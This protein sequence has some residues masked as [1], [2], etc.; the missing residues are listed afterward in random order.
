MSDGGI[1]T[2]DPMDR[3]SWNGLAVIVA[4]GGSACAEPEFPP[5]LPGGAGVVSH[6]SEEF[7]KRPDTLRDEVTVATHAPTIDF[8]FYPGQ[9]YPGKPWSVWGDGVAADG[10]YFSAI[11]DHLA[12]QGTA[13][14]YEFDPV[15]KALR[16][17]VDVKRLLALPAGHYVPGKI[18]S[19]VDLGKDGW[20]YYATHRGSTRVTTEEFHYEGDWILRTHPGTGQSEV[21][22]RGPVPKHCIPC[23]VLDPERLIFYGGTAPGSDG[24]GGIQFFAYDIGRRELLHA[25]EGGPARAMIFAKSTGRVYFTPGKEESPLMRYDPQSGGGPVAIDGQIGIRAATEETSDGIV[26]TVSSGQGAE[27]VLYAFNTRTEEIENL[28]PAAVGTQQYIT[29]IDVDPSG[30]FLYYVP[31]A[32][33][34]SEKDGC[35]VVQFDLRTRKKKVVAFPHPFFAEKY[36]STLQGTF[37]SAIDPAGDKLYITWNNS[38]DGK[39][40]DTCALT[41][42]HIPESERE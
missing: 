25:G 6:T 3:I 35:A 17:L 4:M 27:A 9:A 26:Y 41:V 32:H 38:R 39:T 42:V 15:A 14:V 34:G 11:G 36:G 33:G 16:E 19:R 40:W 7:L 5:R 13:R 31:G 1:S 8:M 37:S 2:N 21:V 30:K 20:L 28:G 12:P 22:V 10:R 24:D 18:H 23:S 29:S